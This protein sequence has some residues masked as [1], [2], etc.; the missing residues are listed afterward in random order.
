MSQT[1]PTQNVELGGELTIFRSAELK[2]ML[3]PV[4]ECGGNVALNLA[5]V[6]EV[7]T[8]GV[9][10]LLSLKH[11]I[12]AGGGEIQITAASPAFTEALHLLGISQAFAA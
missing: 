5:A 6:S 8:A 11:S 9:Q 12:A 4:A 2:E 3:L 1:G 7:D 10:L